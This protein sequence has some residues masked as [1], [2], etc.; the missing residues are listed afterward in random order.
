M[1][2]NEVSS[3]AGADQR[4]NSITS[5]HAYT[6]NAIGLAKRVNP[7]EVRFSGRDHFL[8]H[9]FWSIECSSETI[10]IKNYRD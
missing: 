4:G 5:C 9:A 1:S 6:E 7:I 10:L 3:L 8:N 2:L